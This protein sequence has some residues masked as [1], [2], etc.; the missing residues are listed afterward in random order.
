[1]TR[2]EIIN[3]FV[4]R[5]APSDRT[6]LRQQLEKMTKDQLEEAY[7][8]IQIQAAE[9]KLLQIE[10][11]RAADQALH[12]LHVQR[13]REPQRRAEAKAQLEQDRATF[14]DAGRTL[15]SFG[16][17]EA[18]FSVIR[19]TLGP[20]FTTYGIRQALAANALSLSPPTQEELNEWTHE[21]IKAHNSKLLSMDIPSLRKLA[22][23]AG[24]RGQAAPPPDETQRVR[25][26]ENHDRSYPL[27]PDELR[28]GDREE[29]IDAAYIRRCPKEVL[30]SLIHKYGAPQIDEA[31]RTRSPQTSP[32]W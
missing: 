28:I 13:I 12:K 10:A 27:L 29:L 22:R 3:V 7:R 21:A 31:L 2:N 23:E 16:L 5:A 4:V 19:S 15:Q 24:A 32:L 26:I 14:N 25:A 17:N 8:V 9:E 11:E 6:E 20:N 1:M 30:K 18:N